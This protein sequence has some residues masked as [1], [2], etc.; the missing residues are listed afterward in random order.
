MTV[1]IEYDLKSGLPDLPEGMFWRVGEKDTNPGWYDKIPHMKPA[2]FIMEEGKLETKTSEVPIYGTQW[3]NKH[4]VVETRIETYEEM[5]EPK[6]LFSQTFSQIQTNNKDN[7]PEFARISSWSSDAKGVEYDWR[8]DVAFGEE[9]ISYIAGILYR[10]LLDWKRSVKADEAFKKAQAK[11]KEEL[12]GDYPPKS[13]LLDSG[14]VEVPEHHDLFTEAKKLMEKFEE[15]G[16]EY[17]DAPPYSRGTSSAYSN[18]ARM[19]GEVLRIR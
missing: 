7:I 2:V 18:A 4:A 13:L 9:G 11:A 17:P 8:Y 3:W 16:K 12:Y 19:L 14:P 1:T 6:V 5:S 10:R 15:Y